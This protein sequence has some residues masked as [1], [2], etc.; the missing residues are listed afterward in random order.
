[1]HRRL[2]APLLK[3][4][5][6]ASQGQPLSNPPPPLGTAT[7]L[8]ETWDNLAVTPFTVQPEHSI[9]RSRKGKSAAAYTMASSFM[10]AAGLLQNDSNDFLVKAQSRKSGETRKC[11]NYVVHEVNWPHEKVPM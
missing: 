7:G 2:R 8:A 10:Q 9:H 4:S 6:H 5:P 3:L 1:M 11:I